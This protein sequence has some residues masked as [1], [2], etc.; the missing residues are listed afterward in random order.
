MRAYERLVADD[1]VASPTNN[2]F[3]TVVDAQ[4]S[5]KRRRNLRGK[6]ERLVWILASVMIVSIGDGS[7]DLVTIMFRRYKEAR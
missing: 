7:T 6:L 5:A 3:N 4:E 1:E 2:A